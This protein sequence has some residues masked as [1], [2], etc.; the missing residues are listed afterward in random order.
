[1]PFSRVPLLPLLHALLL[2][3]SE[4]VGLLPPDVLLHAMQGV[5]KRVHKLGHHFEQVLRRRAHKATQ[6]NTHTHTHI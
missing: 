3:L 6:S 2:L 1:M 5:G 4:P